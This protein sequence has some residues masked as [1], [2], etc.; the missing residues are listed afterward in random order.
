Y[1]NKTIDNHSIR[2][3]SILGIGAYGVVYLGR[4]IHAPYQQVAVKL[5]ANDNRATR[6]EI[7]LHAHVSDHANILS[8]KKVIRQANGHVFLVLE[9]A[10]QGD[11]FSAITHHGIVGNNQ[12]IRH[13]FLQLLEAVE[14]CHRRGISHRDLKPENILLMDGL[15]VKLADFGLATTQ[16][17]SAEFGC[18]STFYFSP[19]CQSGLLRDN[20]KIKGYGTQQNDIWS[21]GVILIN[22]VTG[23]NPWRQATMED[24]TFAAYTQQPDHFFSTILPTISTELDELLQRIFCL[25]PAHRISLFELK[26]RILEC[27]SF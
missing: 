13:V 15:H 8:L 2:L 10:T 26:W 25:D 17:V 5:L 1:L 4:K 14:H 24:S 3:C 20:K 7:R 19:E 16:S 18:G 22:L 9:Y 27:R 11:L 23:R 6:A 21:L 12:N